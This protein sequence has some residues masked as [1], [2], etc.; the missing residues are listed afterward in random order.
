MVI[1]LR[2]SGGLSEVSYSF[3]CETDFGKLAKQQ[4]S[5]L[6]GGNAASCHA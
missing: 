3:I 5:R 2:L 6:C 1:K 4:P